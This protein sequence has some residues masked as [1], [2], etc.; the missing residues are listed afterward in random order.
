MSWRAETGGYDLLAIYDSSRDDITFRVRAK[1]SPTEEIGRVTVTSTEP[2][3][4]TELGT[5]VIPPG[6]TYVG[7]QIDEPTRAKVINT[8][9]AK[10]TEHYVLP[11][12]GRTMALAI[13]KREKQGAY[14]T[15]D[16]ESLAK[17]L[18][19]DMRGISHDKHLQVTFKP[20]RLPAVAPVNDS[21]NPQAE[22]K[23]CA[24][25]T[26]ERLPHNI[27][28]IKFDGFIASD[29]CT[30]VG[31][32]AMTFLAGV[33]ALIFDL[34]DNRGGS[35]KASALLSYLF[36]QPTHLSD[37]FD[38]PTGRTTQTW[39]QPSHP[40]KRLG[41]IPVYV[42]TSRMTFSAAES[43]TYELQALKRATVVGEVTG[44][45]S[46]LTNTE[47]IDDRFSIRVPYGRPI[48]PITK[49]DWEGV[50]IIPD[51]KVPA[52]EALAAAEKLA[53]EELQRRS[54]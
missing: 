4:V 30:E 41:R 31:A 9:I 53:S 52:S 25:D 16:A 26:V 6:A 14:S 51:V 36:E 38:R 28:Y 27:G 44:G 23:D 13:A 1:A 24:F 54:K 3:Q 29:V 47:R 19:A 10:L 8:S 12:V 45:G 50:G 22:A 35:E 32:A 18:T 37:F 42:L 46:H 7:F 5:F 40:E 21:A 33:E 11:E 2:A 34:R 17:V 20:F 49:T 39:I 48:N 15:T 43:F